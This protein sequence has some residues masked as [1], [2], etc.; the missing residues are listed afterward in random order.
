MT[1][2]TTLACLFDLDG[3]LVDSSAA[4]L[5]AYRSA[6]AEHEIEPTPELFRMVRAGAARSAVLD[7]VFSRHDPRWHAIYRRK[8]E[9]YAD[10]IEAACAP[11]HGAK[12]CLALCQRMHRPVAVVSNSRSTS[13]VLEASGLRPYVKIVVDGNEAPPKPDPQG[14]HLALAR[15][16]IEAEHAI[17]F[18]DAEEGARAALNAGLRTVVVGGLNLAEAWHCWDRLSSHKLERWL[19]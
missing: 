8:A 3:L 11:M 10:Q 14:Y 2:E 19:N 7:S 1:T 4:H 15:L 12:E 16:G 13:K 17:A 6:F 9:L 5:E 18:E